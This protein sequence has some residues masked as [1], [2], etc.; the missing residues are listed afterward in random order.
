MMF[1]LAGMQRI[2]KVLALGVLLLGPSAHAID[3]NDFSA[4][5][6]LETT[7]GSEIFTCTGVALN[8]KIALTAAHCAAGA[9]SIRVSSDFLYNPNSNS[10]V[11]VQLNR[12]RIHP[13]YSP[14][15]SFYANDIAILPLSNPLPANLNYIPLLQDIRHP[16]QGEWLE[17]IGYGGRNGANR[18]TW[19]TESFLGT[20]PGTLLTRDALSVEGDSGGPLYYR[21]G[22][23]L[24]L[25]GIHSTMKRDGSQVSAAAVDLRAQRSWI[26]D[27][28]TQL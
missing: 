19:T 15:A 26:L 7:R 6:V 20:E 18:K 5:V 12:V 24:Y 28:I 3:W 27:I 13:K 25:L 22:A 2:S 23:S 16:A 11:P 21:N 17:R 4:S 9:T 14:S 8:P 10:F 1:L